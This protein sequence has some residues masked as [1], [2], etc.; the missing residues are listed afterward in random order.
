MVTA[1]LVASL[2]VVGIIALV[3]VLDA[4]ARARGRSW[5]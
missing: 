3:W 5:R 2:G 1:A 4:F